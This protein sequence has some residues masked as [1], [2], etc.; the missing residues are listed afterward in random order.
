MSMSPRRPA[1]TRQLRA[2]LLLSLMTAS[3]QT[4]SSVSFDMPKSR[5]PFNAYSP[6][7]VPEPPLTNSPLL[8]QLIRDGKLYLSLK[9]A[10]RLALENNLD[11]AIA[12]YNLPIANTDILRTKAGGIFRAVNAGV[13]QGPPC[14]EVGGVAQE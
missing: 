13:V 8:S 3:A 9:D 10:I 6:N 12:R 11:L 2:W 4:T 1:K 7:H 5:N 14:G